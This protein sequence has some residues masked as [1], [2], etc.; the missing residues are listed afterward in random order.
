MTT[1]QVTEVLVLSALSHPV[2][3]RL[4][5]I[6]K[7]YGPS[8]VG[9]LSD[10]TGE[11]V[12]SISHHVKVLSGCGLLAQVPELARDRRERWWGLAQDSVRWSS[13]DFEGD[14]VS[15]AVAAAAQRLVLEQHV[16]RERDWMG[17]SDIERA[18]W[19]LGPF[20]TDA[21]AR[22]TDDELAELGREVVALFHAWAS[23]PVPDDG[24]DREPVYLFAHGI[25]ATP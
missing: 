23:R 19:P 3:A 5:Q 7:V 13:N 2:R 25:P 17:A 22:L 16:S 9:G 15:E 8:T 18:R 12:G 6:L 21:W 4:M 24:L 11:A 20:S 10:R 1:R 14:P